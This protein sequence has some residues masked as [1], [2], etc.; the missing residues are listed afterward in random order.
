MVL[1]NFS[2]DAGAISIP[3]PKAGIWAEKINAQITLNVPAD[4]A[5][6][7]VSVPSWYGYVFLL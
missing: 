3:F 2:G 7:T 5:S 6:L 4:G 1:L